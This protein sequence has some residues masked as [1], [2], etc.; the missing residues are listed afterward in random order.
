MPR[1]V[2]TDHGADHPRSRGVYRARTVPVVASSGSSPLARG[3]LGE[4]LGEGAGLGI[5]PARAGFTRH[6]R[7][8]G[9]RRGDHP[10]SRGVY[11]I[12]GVS[13]YRQ[14]GSSPL[15]RGLRPGVGRPGMGCR[16]IPARAGFTPRKPRGSARCGDHP[17]SRGV[18]YSPAT[19]A[20]PALG[21][22]PLAR[23]LLLHPK[24]GCYDGGIIPARAGFT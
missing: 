7:R 11:P 12:T 19:P 14:R 23:G 22:S 4:Q 9:R 8:D 3:L 10:R 21:S 5:I 18:Y 15:A 1:R 13:D 16:I 2:S 17:R 24:L 6:R 20:T